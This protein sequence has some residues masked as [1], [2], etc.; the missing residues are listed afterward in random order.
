MLRRIG[1]G[2]LAILIFGLVACS[3]VKKQQVVAVDSPHTGTVAP[4][5]VQ[6][7]P[8]SA[9]LPPAVRQLFEKIEGDIA[10]GHFAA[11]ERSLQ[12]AQRLAPAESRVYLLWG[13]C[14]LAQQRFNQAEQ[15]YRR[16]LS[17]SRQDSQPYRIAERALRQL[18]IVKEN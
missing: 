12:Q 11:A 6:Q 16:A 8:G 9:P 18:G 2:L 15:M 1:S 3:T 10:R 17:L 14:A 4:V 7:T 5:S 13:E